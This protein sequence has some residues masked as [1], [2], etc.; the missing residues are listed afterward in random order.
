MSQD[1]RLAPLERD[2]PENRGVLRQLAGGRRSDEPP[3]ARPSSMSDP[4]YDSGS[5]PDV[6]ERVW[7][8]LGRS[9]PRACRALVFG[10]PALV[11]ASRGLVLCVALGTEYAL[12]VP[13]ARLQDAE[14]KGLAAFHRYRT[15]GTSLDLA[16]FGPAWRFG[17]WHACEADWLRELHA[18]LAAGDER[19]PGK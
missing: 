15:S 19:E 4:Y 17:G 16:G 5:H 18:E 12:R 7:D 3:I 14:Q 13:P 2:H 10:T 9:L 8:D 11:H 6:V 1:S